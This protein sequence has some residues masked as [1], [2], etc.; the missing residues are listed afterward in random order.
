VVKSAL[1]R[2]WQPIVMTAGVVALVSVCRALGFGEGVILGATPASGMALAATLVLRRAGALAAV[3]GFAIADLAWGLTAGETATDAVGHGMA[4]LL[5]AATMRAFARRRRPETKTHEWLIF[6][7]GVAVFTAVAAVSVLGGA[8]AGLLAQK[9]NL[10]TAPLLVAAFEPLGLLT[11]CSIL[12]NLR[13]FRDV[14]TDPRPAFGIF[15][16]G[17]VLLGVLWLLL[18]LP[19]EHVSPSGVTL[20]LAVPFCLWVAMQRRSLDGAALSFVA[21]YV[22]MLMILN[23]A[24]S[25]TQL[26]Y[27]TTV[28]YLNL[29]VA[30]CQLVHSVNLDRLKALAANAAHRAELERRVTER[31]ARLAVMT[32]RAV[33]ADAAKTRVLATISHEVVTPLSGVIGLASVVL[34]RNLD[35]ELRRNIGVIRKSGLHLLEVI[36]R[37][38]DYARLE[39]D[40]FP[41]DDSDFDLREVVD[42]VLD[43]AR[44]SRHATGIEF[45][46]TIAPGLATWR[47]GYRKGVRQILTNLVGNAAKFT[48]RGI[49][50]V[51][52]LPGQAEGIRLE[53]EDTGIGISAE[54]QE[55]IFEPFEQVD[56]TSTRRIG[57]TGLGLSICAELATRMGGR[58]GVASNQGMGALF[59]VELPLTEAAAARALV[60]A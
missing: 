13:E 9:P 30:T 39:H 29:L 32:E 26:D 1:N 27:F 60:G 15:A 24:G 3:A 53:V 2:A 52:V 45:H 12:A 21:A 25:V 47:H 57:G 18:S 59:W 10:W 51:R 49:V 46:A 22:G 31:T 50:A 19:T 28:L 58:I 20:M 41:Y 14:R 7:A 4:A 56:A 6:L 37:I 55:R 40:P 16:L 48:E 44:F 5:A 23:H 54:L 17:L 8:A 33:A 43:E 11:F 36:D 38:L 42:E 35:P 34:E